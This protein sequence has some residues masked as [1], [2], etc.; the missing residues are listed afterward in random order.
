M[1]LGKW[2]FLFCFSTCLFLFAT[3]AAWSSDERPAKAVFDFRVETAE[4][5]ELMLESIYETYTQ[6]KEEGRTPDFVV[7]FMGPSV[8][9][10]SSDPQNVSGDERNMFQKIVKT[11]SR[12]AEDGIRLEGDVTAAYFAGIDPAAFLA[13][14]KP[15]GNGMVSLINYQ[16]ESYSLVPVY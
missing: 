3:S 4:A 5:A 12:M 13:E 6:F 14:I 7:V 11:I 9:I 1:K 16:A 2:L 8:E 10:I 15:V